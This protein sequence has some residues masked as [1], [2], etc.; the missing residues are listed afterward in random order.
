MLKRF[1]NFILPIWVACFIRHKISYYR[2]K[3]NLKIAYRYDLKRYSRYSDSFSTD[4]QQKLIGKI[5]REYHV[6]EKGLTMPE[7]RLGFGKDLVLNLSKDCIQYTEKYGK[8]ETQL[9]HAIGVIFEYENFH[10]KKNYKIDDEILYWIKCLRQKDTNAVICSQRE[11]TKDEYFK[12]KESPFP[13]FSK[14][15]SSIRN[16]SD[17]EIPLKCIIEALDIARNTPSACNRQCWRTY[18]FSD[19]VQINKI[20][21][22]QGGNRGFGHL[23]NKLI[24]I[25]AEIG[26]FTSVAERNE[27]FIDGG[28]YAMNLLYALHYHDVA[29]CI[30][31]CS[32]TPEKDKR[33]RT[34]CQIKNSEVF[35]AMIACGIPPE[36]FKIAASKRYELEAT[37]T[38][39]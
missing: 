5:I 18:V 37:N 21:D 10:Q 19:K 4:T 16:Y 33:L 6:L 28:I 7:T 38:N 17:E 35:I 32:N 26:V 14:S 12:Y 23:A 8:D 25:A 13:E 31:N 36:S 9:I 11:V 1:I 15:R 30:L 39:T 27:A 3:K 29:S 2:I 24:V 20:L 22:F 34:L